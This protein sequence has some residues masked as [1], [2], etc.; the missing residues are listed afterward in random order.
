MRQNMQSEEADKEIRACATVAPNLLAEARILIVCDDD[1]IAER[2]KHVLWE[3]GLASV[4]VKGMTAGCAATRSGRFQTVFT[5]PVLNDGSWKRLVDLASNLDLGFVV[6][7]VASNFDLNEWAHA[8]E[9]GAFE[10][11]DV[12]HELP[13]AAEVA[14][15]A[16]WAAYLK[17]VGPCPEVATPTMAA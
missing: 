6:V 8:L 14:R 2:L 4:Y 7:L 11:L 16:S 13:K 9:E 5:T 15:R 1:S 17:G 3:A 10:V 12:L